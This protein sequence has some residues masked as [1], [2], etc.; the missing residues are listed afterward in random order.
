MALG[1]RSATEEFE[2]RVNL[3]AQKRNRKIHLEAPERT[4]GARPSA[5]FLSALEQRDW[6]MPDPCNI[7]FE[8]VPLGRD[9]LRTASLLNEFVGLPLE[10]D[11]ASQ[12]P[13][14][15]IRSWYRSLPATTRKW[16]DVG[17]LILFCTF[18]G[19]TGRMSVGVLLVPL[20]ML[21]SLIAVYFSTELRAPTGWL[22]PG[23]IA[24]KKRGK[25]QVLRRGHG[26]LWYDALEKVLWIPSEDGQFVKIKCEPRDGLLAIWAWL[27]TAEPPAH[28]QLDD[29][30]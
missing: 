8:P 22:F 23:L 9:P 14:K 26:C 16:F 6:P 10:G 1:T 7:P 3:L 20:L 5:V 18:M 19:L 13:L 24:A 29:I 17:P 27:N 2:L 25:T 11:S 15:R 30:A 21:G 4:T 28:I 12:G